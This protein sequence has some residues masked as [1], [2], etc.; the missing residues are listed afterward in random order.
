MRNERFVPELSSLPESQYVQM[1]AYWESIWAATPIFQRMLRGWRADW[2]KQQTDRDGNPI[3]SAVSDDADKGIR[4][5]QYEATSAEVELDFWLDTFG[6]DAT[7]PG[8]IR[9]LVIDLRAIDA[10]CRISAEVD[11]VLD[12]RRNRACKYQ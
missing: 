2:F 11:V 10:I 3:F 4:I 5:I 9:E 12:H 7:Q 1:Q 8:T 6:G